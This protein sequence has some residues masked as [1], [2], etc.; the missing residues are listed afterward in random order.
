MDYEGVPHGRMR[1]EWLR[2][3]DNDEAVCRRGAH[4]RLSRSAASCRGLRLLPHRRRAELKEFVC[5]RVA[6]VLDATVVRLLLVPA[7]MKLAS[8]ANLWLLRGSNR[9]AEVR[10]D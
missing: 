4:P 7:I 5:A 6:V 9:P 3:N 8:K 10:I 1:E 2:T